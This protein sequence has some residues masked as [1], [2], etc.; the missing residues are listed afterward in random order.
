MTRLIFLVALIAVVACTPSTKRER[1]GDIEA[2]STARLPDID[3]I[4]TSGD[5]VKLSNLE[6]PLV[7]ILFTPDCDHCQREATDISN[8]I[9]LF[10]DY[11]LYFVSAQTSAV[12]NEFAKKYNLLDKSDVVFAQGPILPVIKILRPTSMPTI[13][14]YDDEGVLVKRFDGET[15]VEDIKEFL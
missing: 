8:H 3:I 6:G 15:K 1:S 7:L 12:M 2:D 14:I 9:D 4:A 5:T 13:L 10:K 11:K